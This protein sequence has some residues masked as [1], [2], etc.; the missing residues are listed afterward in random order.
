MGGNQENELDN[1]TA[2]FRN[3]DPV[4]RSIFADLCK[5]RDEDT[6]DVITQLMRQRIEEVWGAYAAGNMYEAQSKNRARRKAELAS[7]ATD[8][9]SQSGDKLSDDFTMS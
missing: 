6:G 7:K 5:S 8:E 9:A 4:W 3:V 1:V 2:T